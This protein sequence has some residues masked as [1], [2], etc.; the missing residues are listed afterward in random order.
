MGINPRIAS[1]TAWLRVGML[2]VGRVEHA[3]FLFTNKE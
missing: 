3:C 1:R 2:G